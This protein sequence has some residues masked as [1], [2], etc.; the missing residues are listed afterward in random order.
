M[1][2]SYNPNR[3]TEVQDQAP[4]DGISSL[5]WSPRANYLAVTSWDSK[6]RCYEIGHNTACKGMQDQGAPILCS[7]FKDDGSAIF[8]GGCMK[9]GMYWDL[10]SNSFTQVAQHENAVNYIRW[11]P[12]MNVLCTTSWDKHIYYWDMRQQKPAVDVLLPEKPYCMDI[13]RN[14]AVCGTANRAIH[15]FDLNN[16]QKPVSSIDSPLKLQSRCLSI[17][18]DGNNQNPMGYALGSIEGRVA[19]QHLDQRNQSKNFAFKCHRHDKDIYA[20]NSID[21]HPTFGT[22]ATAGSD[23]AFNFWDKDNKQRL[24]PFSR[25]ATSITCGRF[26]A[27]GEIYAYAVSYDWS[28]GIEHY[29]PA[30]QRNSILLHKVNKG[31]IESRSRSKKR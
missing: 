19:I 10:G 26:N 24:K 9:K 11:I 7:D 1:A 21:F 22:F 4:T 13:K 16:P 20:V 6:V 25:A 15:A 2:A 29:N 31:E 28:A 14:V 18:Y 5:S 8:T 17:F 30:N 3:D 12:N 23:G 27:T